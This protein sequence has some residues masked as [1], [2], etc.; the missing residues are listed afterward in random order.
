MTTSVSKYGP[1]AVVTGASDGIGREFARSLAREGFKLVVV[2]RRR[3]ALEALAKE[4][5]GTEVRV[6]EAD[7]GT[8]QGVRRVE[9]ETRALDVGLVVASAGFGTSGNFLDNRLD[10]ELSM[11]DVNCRAVAATVHHFGQRPSTSPS[12]PTS[13]R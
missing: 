11:I 1:W 4:L 9:D 3:A 10:D 13:P 12:A 2:A 6:V 5:S 8:S 7:L